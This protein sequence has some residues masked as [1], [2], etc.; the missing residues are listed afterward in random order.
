MVKETALKEGTLV[1]KL[2]ELAAFVVSRF[3]NRRFLFLAAIMIA[4]WAGLTAVALKMMVHYIQLLFVGNSL[5]TY[6]WARA[7]APGI[8]ILATIAFIRVFLKGELNKGTAHVLYAI[9]R[10]GS[11]LDK[12]ETYSQ[13]VTSG[14]TVS[15]GGSAGLESPIVQTGA[16]I[17]STFASWFPMSYRDRTLMLAC[18]SAAGIAAAF[19]AP[20]TGVLFALEVLLVDIHIS[21]FI[22]ILIAGAIGALCSKIILHEEIVLS[23]SGVEEFNYYN[24]P[25]Y[26]V[27]G[28]VCGIVA[29][30]YV[31][32]LLSTQSWLAKLLPGTLPRWLFGSVL[33]GG[34][35]FLFPAHFGEGYLMVKELASDTALNAFAGSVLMPFVSGQKWLLVS[36]VLVMGL[37]K[38]FAVSFTLGSGGNGGN[39]AP[40]LFVG[41]CLGYSFASFLSMTGYPY[42]VVANFC[43][44]GMAGV[45][46]G[47]FHSPLTAI[48]LIAEVTGGYSLMIPL[49]IVVALS[50]AT[51]RYLNKHSLDEMILHRKLG[52]F[53]YNKDTQLLSRLATREFVETDFVRIQ[54]GS[55]MRE[56]VGA[57]SKSKRN[58]FPVVD[59]NDQLMGIIALEDIREKMFDTALYD[60]VKV[61]QLMRK[62]QVIA[63]PSDDMTV[64]MEKFDKY[65]V[66]NIPVVDN[67]QYL[68][69][70]S[71][72][73]IF[74]NYRERL[75]SIE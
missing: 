51:S 33:L 73:R 27:M 14:L 10:R 50:T 38:V 41:S 25:F 4:L 3:S 42:I 13:A 19:N 54:L 43:L 75:R 46:T 63:S 56:L 18:G 34:M 49:M 32:S 29:V 71:K 35:I 5:E 22:P 8:G 20:I 9:A 58:I 40:S 15:M 28:V 44:V 64:I 52:H 7:V 1:R 59:V 47:I 36:M 55:S 12:Q 17:G 48:F 31:R 66:W 74:S 6:P 69:F 45:L 23:F 37:L 70:I 11:R 72:S 26:V 24:T 16:A 60:T 30:V 57:V 53:S 2:R 65:N 39:F 68:G 62:P 61:D 21:S 67:G